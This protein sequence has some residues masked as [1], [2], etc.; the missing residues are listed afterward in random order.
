MGQNYDDEPRLTCPTVATP[1]SDDFRF[2]KY[3]PTLAKIAQLKLTQPKQNKA[4]KIRYRLSNVR[5]PYPRSN[6]LSKELAIVSSGHT[7]GNQHIRTAI[8]KNFQ[9][10][11]RSRFQSVRDLNRF[12]CPFFILIGVRDQPYGTLTNER[13]CWTL[14]FKNKEAWE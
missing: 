6:H 1:S 11:I 3:R 14:Y 2:P 5:S 12:N 9:K 8:A 10:P 4:A 13:R 7:L